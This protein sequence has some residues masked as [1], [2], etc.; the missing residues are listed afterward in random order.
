VLQRP[1]HCLGLIAVETGETGTVQLP[2][3][4]DDDWFGKRICLA[5]QTVGLVARDFDPLARFA[6]AFQCADLNDPS[7]MDCSRFDRPVLLNGLWLAVRARIGI[8]HCLR[9]G[10]GR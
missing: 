2:F 4:F 7:A 9:S 8:G 5:E 1:A 3:A 10:G 6:L